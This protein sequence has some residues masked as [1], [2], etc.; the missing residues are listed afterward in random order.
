MGIKSAFLNAFI[1]ELVYVDE[2]SG[3][4]DH[5]YTNNVYRLSKAL[6]GLKKA[7]RGMV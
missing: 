7:P 4:E 2:P 3:F 5:G 6:Y 1:N